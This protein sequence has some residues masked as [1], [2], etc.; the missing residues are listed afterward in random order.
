MIR[1]GRRYAQGPEVGDG[2]VDFRVWAPEH[3]RVELVLG[4]RRDPI[5]LREEEDG[6]WSV[7][8]EHARVGERYRYRL[9]GLPPDLP[10][11]AA[12]FLPE[13]PHESAQVVD[14]DSFVWTDGTWR[15]LHPRNHVLYELHVGS[16]SP[17]GTWAGL[18]AKLPWLRDLG[19]TTLEVMPVAE[20][21]GPFG[22]GYD[23]VA[24]FA[25]SHL[26]GSP[27]ELR[28]T[29]DLAHGFGLGVIL[30]VV[31]NHFGSGG[32][33]SAKYSRFYAGQAKTGWGM[34]FNY[35]GEGCH[36]VRTLAVDNAVYWIR[37]FHLDG[38][39]LDATHAIVD[40]S[41]EH[42][43]TA[44]TRAA[45]AAAPGRS[46]F[47]VGENEPQDT[48]LLRE[49]AVPG[50]GRG[51]DALW[52]DD[53]H[54]SFRV[55]LTGRRQAYFHD[56]AGTA[57]EWCAAL[58]G[59]L[60]YQ[61]Q[62]Y[63]WQDKPRGRPTRGIPG[64]AFVGFMENHDQVANS[65]WATRLWQQSQPAQYR[66]LAALFLLGPWLPMIFQGQEWA[67]S[68]PFHYFAGHEPELAQL[69]KRG[70]AEFLAQ[71]PGCA[72]HPDLLADPALPSTFEASRLRWDE[73]ETGA[74]AVAVRLHRDLL[75]LR[76]EEPTVGITA[77]PGVRT[78][79][80]ALAPS[81]AL[82][83]YFADAPADD[84]EDRILIVNLGAD[85]ELSAVVD[86]LLAP[87]APDHRP[88]WRLLWT[89]ED[90][91]YGGHGCSEPEQDD[92]RWIIPGAAAVLLS[93]APR[94]RA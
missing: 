70:R 67:S 62:R 8:V 83:R 86:P 32:D 44:L 92:G 5:A 19:V 66:A 29:V 17:A 48:R 30:D 72:R 53:L 43:I 23:G 28:R 7:F 25:P 38:L 63:D 81:C 9:D 87:A 46:L 3:R 50:V 13:G 77:S 71:F 52:N 33:Y 16:F 79:A 51:L 36:G 6:Y 4:G 20:F 11:P 85:L 60:F 2:G 64:Q 1:P 21:A 93:P 74:H 59:G 26:Y 24:W 82:V 41:T 80:V 40:G 15:G 68:V 75:R 76:R 56:Y 31:Y 45:R 22:W 18:R 89:S 35:D 10:D 42:V 91:R 90:P 39:R 12:R 69:V 58:T 84:P 57:R 65:L 54:H 37:E 88:R 73:C 61:G 27:D 49:H 94:Q 78:Q 47:M 14:G 55:A 34:A